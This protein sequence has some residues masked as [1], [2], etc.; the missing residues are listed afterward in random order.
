MHSQW[1]LQDAKNKFSEM[2]SAACAGQPQVVTKRGKPSVVVLSMSEYE[3]GLER[4]KSP[5]LRFTEFLLS[6]LFH[7]ALGSCFTTL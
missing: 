5:V 1:T 2:V 7:T 6:L 3:K 4:S